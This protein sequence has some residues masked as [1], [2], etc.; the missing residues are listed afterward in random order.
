MALS[1]SLTVMM[2]LGAIHP[3][4]GA[5][6]VAVLRIVP[7]PILLVVVFSTT[8][9]RAPLVRKVSDHDCMVCRIVLFRIAASPAGPM[10][11]ALCPPDSLEK[12]QFRQNRRA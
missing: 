8:E 11:R 6:A 5:V 10:S 7:A 9:E 1:V 2:R 12:I 4:A 3:P